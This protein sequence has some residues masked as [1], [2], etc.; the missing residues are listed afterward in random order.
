MDLSIFLNGV[1]YR[2]TSN[3]TIREQSGQTASSSFDLLL[4][5][6]PLPLAHTRVEVYWESV[7]FYSG[8]IDTV[9][10]PYYS[11]RFETDVVTINVNDLKTIFTRRIVSDTWSEVYVHEI[12]QDIFTDY[13]EEENL[14]LGTIEEF[15]TYFESYTASSIT[16][17]NVLQE[18]EESCGAI[19]QICVDGE[20]NFISDE[21]FTSVTPPTHL[22][23]MKMTESGGDLKT[24]QRISGATEETSIQTL[25]V[26]WE[27]S[28]SS[29][30]LGYQITEEPAVTVN[31][32]PVGVA[33]VGS[34]D[35]ENGDTVFL[36]SDSNNYLILNENATT[37]PVAGDIISVIYKGFYD[38]DIVVE[39]EELKAEIASLSG[40]SGKIET[41]EVDTT[42]KSVADGETYAEALL[43]EKSVRKQVVTLTCNDIEKSMLL[44]S[45]YLD[46]PDLNIQGTFVITERTITRFYDEEF[47]I[48]LKL[49]NKGFYTRYGTVLNNNTKEMTNLSVN[50]NAVIG[51]TSYVYESQTWADEFKVNRA[52]MSFTC[53][54]T[55][56]F[57]PAY[58]EGMTAEGINDNIKEKTMKMT[59]GTSDIFGSVYFAGMPVYGG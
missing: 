34:E 39:N 33:L 14:T 8:L 40:T 47:R 55:D 27:T 32:S 20:F 19:S 17:Y 18:L 38:I 7:L 1:E 5:S 13:L 36:W 12:V 3:F 48:A 26:T 35:A 10:T 58:F 2:L 16:V 42:I 23:K 9:D 25:V 30:A 37:P 56:I 53:G 29:V 44:Y 54:T 4:E 41:V 49:K 21:N 24:V 52:F 57:S 22:T 15:D 6:K 43:E 31:S 46:Y 59:C 50:A 51:K 11:S 28:Q 45:W